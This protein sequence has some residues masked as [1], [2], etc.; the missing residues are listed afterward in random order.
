[1]DEQWINGFREKLDQHY[2]WPSLYIFK[3]IVPKGKE[4]DLKQLFPLHTPTEKA[5]KQG[6]YTSITMQMMMPSSDAVIEVYVKASQV[7]GIVAL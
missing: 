2:T 1:M 4:G 5:S 3:F 7:E 6:N